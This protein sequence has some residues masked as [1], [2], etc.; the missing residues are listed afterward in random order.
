VKQNI[1]KILYAVPCLLSV[2]IFRVYK[3]AIFVVG[4]F[5]FKKTSREFFSVVSYFDP[6][7]GD[8]KQ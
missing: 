7:A 2:Y 6:G 4:A 3:Y 1:P 8:W 5:L